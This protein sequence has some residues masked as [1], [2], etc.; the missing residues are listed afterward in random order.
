[1]Q[2]ECLYVC[3]YTVH[4]HTHTHTHT[5]KQALRNFT[6]IDLTFIGGETVV[7]PPPPPF[8]LPRALSLTL[9]LSLFFSLFFYVYIK[10]PPLA[11]F[12]HT[13]THTLLY[14]GAPAC[15]RLG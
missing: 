6:S 1:M 5:Q 13:D 4:T 2:D 7:A 15:W 9:S 14:T 3:V 11:A 10:C 12:M 8:P